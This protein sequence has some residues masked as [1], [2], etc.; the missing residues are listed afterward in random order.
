MKINVITL[1]ISTAMHISVWGINKLIIAP[2]A[3]L[4]LALVAWYVTKRH[5]WTTDLFSLLFSIALCLHMIILT[6]L[7]DDKL[8]LEVDA[9]VLRINFVLIF[10]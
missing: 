5:L 9:L 3:G 8:E 6:F 2:F 10:F 1:V 4:L 7:A